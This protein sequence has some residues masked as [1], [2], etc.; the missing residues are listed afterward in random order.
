MSFHHV[1]VARVEGVVV[2]YGDAVEFLAASSAE[3]EWE[4]GSCFLVFGAGWAGAFASF[5]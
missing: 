1:D 3:I 2:G 5:V 4:G